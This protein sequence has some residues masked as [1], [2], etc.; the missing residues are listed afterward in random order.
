MADSDFLSTGKMCVKASLTLWGGLKV[1][2]SM[3]KNPTKLVTFEQIFGRLNTV[4]LIKVT[5]LHGVFHVFKIVQTV[6]NQAKLN[7]FSM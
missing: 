1:Q 5:F 7:I 2:Q 4:T 3:G 6:S